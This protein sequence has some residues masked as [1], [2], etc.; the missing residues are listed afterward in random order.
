MAVKI[1]SKEL[2]RQHGRHMIDRVVAEVDTHSR[3][4]HPHIVRLLVRISR[5]LLSGDASSH[6]RC[7]QDFFEDRAAVYIVMEP[8]NAGDL[9]RLLRRHGPLATPAVRHFG[10][11]LL[12]AVAH[13]HAAGVMHRD[14]KLSNL[15]LHE[16]RAGEAEAASSEAEA[17]GAE[18]NWW[19][20]LA[21]RV[22]DFGLAVAL[23]GPDEERLTVCG[24]P[25]YMAPEI[26]GGVSASSSGISS[27]GRPPVQPVHHHPGYG[28]SIDV[29]SVGC[30]LFAMATGKPPPEAAPGGGD[31]G[32]G[33]GAMGGEA[34]ANLASPQLH[35]QQLTSLASVSPPALRDLIAACLATDPARRPAAAAAL[36]H[37]FFA[38]AHADEG[39]RGGRAAMG[40]PQP[41]GSAGPAAQV[42]MQAECVEGASGS[43]LTPGH[44]AADSGHSMDPVGLAAPSVLKAQ[45]P[46][47]P[48]RASEPSAAATV[49]LPS[50][51]AQQP[52]P[53]SCGADTSRRGAPELLADDEDGGALDSLLSGLR[54]MQV[55]DAGAAADTGKPGDRPPSGLPNES[56]ARQPSAAAPP[57]H[58]PAGN[59]GDGVLRAPTATPVVTSERRDLPVPQDRLGPA[60][61]HSHGAPS[62][63]PM[64]LP[65]SVD[66][67]PAGDVAAVATAAEYLAMHAPTATVSAAASAGTATAAAGVPRPLAR[68][69]VP[70]S[71]SNAAS[72]RSSVGLRGSVAVVDLR[73]E[74]STWGGKGGEPSLVIPRIETP[75]LGSLI[76]QGLEPD[77]GAFIT[78]T[79]RWGAAARPPAAGPAPTA[80]RK[81]AGRGA[82]RDV[83]YSAGEDGGDDGAPSFLNSILYARLD[84]SVAADVAVSRLVPTGGISGSSAVRGHPRI[85]S[86][87][88]HLRGDEPPTS[89]LGGSRAGGSL[90]TQQSGAPDSSDSRAPTVPAAV[91]GAIDAEALHAAVPVT[92][93]RSAAPPETPHRADTLVTEARPADPLYPNIVASVPSRGVSSSSGAAV[94]PPGFRRWDSLLHA[95]PSSAVVSSAAP[96]GHAS[97]SSRASV[98]ADAAALPRRSVSP[99]ELSWHAS[100]GAF[101]SSA[102]SSVAMRVSDIRPLPAATASLSYSTPPP[103]P[104]PPAEQQPYVAAAAASEKQ[105]QQQQSTHSGWLPAAAA[106][107]VPRF[108]LQQ[109]QQVTGN[110]P[111]SPTSLPLPHAPPAT[112]TAAA[113]SPAT[114]T[115]AVDPLRAAV[116]ALQ[117]R[118]AAAAEEERERKRVAARAARA[119]QQ[120]AEQL[121]AAYSSGRGGPGVANVLAA[122]E[123]PQAQKQQSWM[124]PIPPA[125][126]LSHQPAAIAVG[127]AFAGTPTTSPVHSLPPADGRKA[128]PARI[129]RVLTFGAPASAT[130]DAPRSPPQAPQFSALA[131]T[132]TGSATSAP[133]SNVTAAARVIIAGNRAPVIVGASSTAGPRHSAIEGSSAREGRRRHASHRG[134]S[135]A[136]AQ[137]QQE[138]PRRLSEATNAS[139]GVARARSRP[140]QSRRLSGSLLAEESAGPASTDASGVSALPLWPAPAR[141]A[142]P[143]GA[144][145]AVAVV[146]ATAVHAAEPASS[147]SPGL[148]LPTR[149]P[150]QL[151]LPVCD[152]SGLAPVQC[153][154]GDGTEVSVDA[155]GCVSVV[156]VAQRTADAAPAKV[157]LDIA[158]AP[159]LPPPRRHPSHALSRGADVRERT[160]V[161]V[162]WEE[163]PVVARPAGGSGTANTPQLH[164]LESLPSQLHRL[165]RTAAR[166]VA[167]L[168]ARTP[169]LATLHPDAVACVMSDAPASASGGGGPTSE[170][171]LRLCSGE[172][173]HAVV[174]RAAVWLTPA[175]V[176]QQRQ[177]GVGSGGGG[178]GGGRALIVIPPLPSAS[179]ASS[180]SSSSSSRAAA[181]AGASY[182]CGFDGSA[183][184]RLPPTPA[185]VP[186]GETHAPASLLPGVAGLRETGTGRS[187]PDPSSPPPPPG[188]PTSSPIAAPLPPPL[189][190]LLALALHCHGVGVA[191][192]GE[193]SALP[194]P[195]AAAAA[196][197]PVGAPIVL[198]IGSPLV[199]PGSALHTGLLRAYGTGRAEE[200]AAA[201]A[202]AEAAGGSSSPA[203]GHAAVPVSRPQR[204]PSLAVTQVSRGAAAGSRSRK[205]REEAQA[206]AAAAAAAGVCVSFSDGSQLRIAADGS[207]VALTAAAARREDGAGGGGGGGGAP[208]AWCAC[209]PGAPSLPPAV[210]QRLALAQRF[211]DGRGDAAATLRSSASGSQ[212]LST[213]PS[214][215]SRA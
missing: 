63:P 73:S 125:H 208:A 170:L 19:S 21:L 155:S 1:I 139:A 178:S 157:R 83:L 197:A 162:T 119:A 88:G 172:G 134:R 25:Q 67:A 65:L 35:Q 27:S 79:N 75:S 61:R 17:G 105:G 8:C 93:S 81:V 164:P 113:A 16:E 183:C 74:D 121:A 166:L 14:L 118:E 55:P 186:R 36:T 127:T 98:C 193:L 148:L 102:P 151:L 58:L 31:G 145:A 24:T 95:P 173:R 192:L 156:G 174:V 159:P 153:A 177:E 152:G 38:E 194:R 40:P 189:R 56:H 120:R 77:A 200:A 214:A 82:A 131:S 22:G 99:Q 87:V 188:A 50:K 20:R 158:V 176:P 100:R 13:M 154:R 9:Y 57:G 15:L 190:L 12:A 211:L 117:A 169:A 92:A 205:R 182:V 32:N 210:R 123:P 165:Y 91:A 126:V 175:P 60:P 10:L 106:A 212:V 62:A 28:A 136:P 132:L 80:A 107:Y 163:E 167:R 122:Y 181:A 111:P 41:L 108:A 150:S 43:A 109:G 124:G 116:K 114:L 130:A 33:G 142:G 2:C 202:P 7:A 161:T 34:A 94:L 171:R 128:S 133:P 97:C 39:R 11:Q 104:P 18:G 185:D 199:P 48:Q 49:A 68:P 146:P 198:R 66:P 207:S 141:A 213:G 84:A 37:P 44:S 45:P 209:G 54:F 72:V 46:E 215:A 70:P 23:S 69:P 203:Q 64:A 53:A 204:A 201:A 96:L 140:H 180:S 138:V 29:F 30:L 110:A 135:T 59:H 85:R 115:A 78:G 6:P 26:R 89:S 195:T 52:L 129:A 144:A 86:G 3:L 149:P 51:H 5:H 101:G 187:R 47:L 184:E 90:P 160:F 196:G 103:P 179:A 168:R 4:Q 143:T 137:Q 191:R 42:S 76:S 147:L 71:L 206:A 112:P